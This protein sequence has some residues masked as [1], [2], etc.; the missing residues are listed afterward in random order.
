MAE[1]EEVRRSRPGGEARRDRL[2]R[3]GCNETAV[4]TVKWEG[5]MQRA[6]SIF[7]E[8][9]VLGRMGVLGKLQSVERKN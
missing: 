1:K 5:R 4:Y 2:R 8:S 6:E 9:S 3:R 7:I